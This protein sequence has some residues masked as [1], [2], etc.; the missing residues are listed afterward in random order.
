MLLAAFELRGNVSLGCLL[1]SVALNSFSCACSQDS[2]ADSNCFVAEEQNVMERMSWLQ[3]PEGWHVR[4]SRPVPLECS[5]PPVVAA[6]LTA[7]L[8]EGK[9]HGVQRK[10]GRPAWRH[11]PLSDTLVFPRSMLPPDYGDVP[12]YASP[13]SISVVGHLLYANIHAG[14][15]GPHLTCLDCSDVAE[16]RLMW[17]IQPPERISE[18][19]GPPIA[20]HELCVVVGRSEGDRRWLELVTCDAKDGTV[21]WR[22][23]LATSVANDGID[24]ARGQRQASLI[25]NLIVVADHAGSVWAFYRD[26]RLKWHYEYDETS[27]VNHASDRV[28]GISYANP[29]VGTPTGLLITARDKGGIVKL[30]TES[31][32]VRAVWE[33]A[34]QEQLRIVGC[35]GQTVI[36]QQ[37]QAHCWADLVA[38]SIVDGDLSAT[39]KSMHAVGPAVMGGGVLL[40]PSL[41]DTE[42][43]PRVSIDLISPI[44]LQQLKKPFE[45]PVDSV[46]AIQSSDPFGCQLFISLTSDAMFVASPTRL[47][48]IEPLP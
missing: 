34:N 10:N 36:V 2:V 21:L 42:T 38:Y 17:S 31:E 27:Q 3:Q 13:L 37:Y 44:S 18:F 12:D 16:G 35:F 9:I 41:R 19:D 23:R 8:S 11:V 20:D 32:E 43:V 15:L 4:W 28:K 46:S 25:D 26:G 5:A 1:L 6:G 40:H 30:S 14:G 29:I 7:W 22:R 45:V 48:S 39:R 24:Y 47:F 33:V